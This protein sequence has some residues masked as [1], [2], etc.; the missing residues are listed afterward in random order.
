M[1]IDGVDESLFDQQ[2][3]REIVLNHLVNNCPNNY[4]LNWNNDI[5]GKVIDCLW[6]MKQAEEIISNPSKV[7]E[8][9]QIKEEN[10]KKFFD[11]MDVKLSAEVGIPT[12]A[13][14]GLEVEFADVQIQNFNPFKS[15]VL[16]YDFDNLDI[17][18]GETLYK[19]TKRPLSITEEESVK[20]E[21]EKKSK[22]EFKNQE[23][24]NEK[25]LDFK[26]EEEIISYEYVD[27]DDDLIIE[28]SNS[29]KRLSLNNF[30]FSVANK[31]I[32]SKLHNL[33]DLTVKNCDLYEL[34]IDNCPNIKNLDVSYNNLSNL[35]YLKNLTNLENL[36]FKD[37]LIESNFGES[38]V[39]VQNN[40]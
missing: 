12:I 33:E 5:K 15:I 19:I 14:F 1:E 39:E 6:R 4:K 21:K 35:N 34:I 25:F 36:S 32:I 30:K 8:S 16:E 37:N 28:K 20:Q 2:D 13:E 10:K 9:E 31:L 38:L 22:K 27:F 18:E 11:K 40:E 17:G 3:S 24:F 23:W 29:L 26:N 7:K